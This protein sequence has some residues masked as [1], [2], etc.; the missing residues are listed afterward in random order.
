[1]TLVSIIVSTKNAAKTLE[2]CLK[3]IK[4]QTYPS[5]ELIVV[6]N[7]S[8]DKTPQIAK[9]Y[10]DQLLTK[11]PERSAQRNFGIQKS[12]GEYIAWFDADM[13]LTPKVIKECIREMEK[14]KKTKALVIPEK[15]VGTGFWADCKA[16]EKKCYLGDRKIEAVRFVEKKAFNKVGKLS[17]SFISGEDWD[18]TSRLRQAD[19]KIGRIKSFVIH[20]E[21]NLKLTDTLKKKY[22]YATRSFP[23]IQRH[24]KSPS[25][26]FLFVF[27]P[28][29]IRNWR[30]LLSNP[31]HTT[32]LF[33][34]K[35]GEFTVGAVGILVS[36]FK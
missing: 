13:Q 3:S 21:G 33:F 19:Y 16:L 20:N 25:D 34:M 12:Q 7:N 22:Y 28:A 11:G 15:S 6:D 29:F 23:Y 32:G 2:T 14:D 35:A 10:A 24:I 17:E 5:I 27:R 36:K 1:M 31:Q 8:K 9:K 4:A 26:I 18:I 30:L